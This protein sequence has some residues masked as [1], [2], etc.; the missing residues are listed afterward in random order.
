MTREQLLAIKGVAIINTPDGY[1][2]DDVMYNES[3]IGFVGKNTGTVG[4]MRC[5]V[6]GKENHAFSVLG[7][8]CAWCG[9]DLAKS[10]SIQEEPK[11]ITIEE[12]LERR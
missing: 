5:P 2:S 7:C 10:I 8:T 3:F 11:E 9:F 6:C 12:E 4:L 1:D